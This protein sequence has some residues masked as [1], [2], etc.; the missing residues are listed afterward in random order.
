MRKSFLKK[1]ITFV[2]GI[3][4][5]TSIPVSAAPE[6]FYNNYHKLKPGVLNKKF[7]VVSSTSSYWKTLFNDSFYL[8]Y[9]TN[10]PINFTKTT[11]YNQ[12]II[13][14]ETRWLSSEPNLYGQADFWILRSGPD[15]WESGYNSSWDYATVTINNSQLQYTTYEFDTKVIMHELGHAFGLDH[16]SNAYDLMYGSAAGHKTNRP[17]ANDVSRINTLHR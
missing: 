4:L 14:C 7:F 10:T 5:I 11:D 1:M 17:S 8:W 16:V 6:G 9:T 13:D 2:L 3:I 12:S 15:T